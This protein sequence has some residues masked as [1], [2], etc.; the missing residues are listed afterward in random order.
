[1]SGHVQLWTLAELILI[2]SLFCSHFPFDL[3]YPG[4]HV[5]VPYLTKFST[6]QTMVQTDLAQA[7][8]LSF[9]ESTARACVRCVQC[10][11]SLDRETEPSTS[12]LSLRVDPGSSSA[13]PGGGPRLD[14]SRVLSLRAS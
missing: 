14:S 10:T 1:M 9:V 2:F 13:Y 11:A 3:F 4:R 5:P 6:V 12:G 8:L 7:R